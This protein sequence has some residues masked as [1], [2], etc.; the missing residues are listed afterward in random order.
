[1]SSEQPIIVAPEVKLVEAP[2]P[3]QLQARVEVASPTPEQIAA[4]NSVFAQDR[5]AQTVANM[6]GLWTSANLLHYLAKDTFDTTEEE[7][8]AKRRKE[9]PGL[10][11]K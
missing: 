5:E 3:E 1:M 7:E 10:P 11:E 2:R 8:E 9:V 6:L 4:A